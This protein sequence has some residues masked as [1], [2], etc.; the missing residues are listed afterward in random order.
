MAEKKE[1]KQRPL[2]KGDF[3]RIAME[4]MMKQLCCSRRSSLLR[5]PRC[6]LCVIASNSLRQKALLVRR[7]LAQY[8]LPLA[9]SV[10]VACASVRLKVNMWC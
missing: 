8:S 3:V 2:K 7:S 6:S 5:L 4:V 10:T 9:M 1:T